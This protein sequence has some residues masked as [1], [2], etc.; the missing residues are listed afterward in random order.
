MSSYPPPTE[1]LPIYNNEAFETEEAGTSSSTGDGAVS[2]LGSIYNF[3]F[4]ATRASPATGLI[5]TNIFQIII[6]YSGAWTGLDLLW[7]KFNCSFLTTF[8]DAS[9]PN[10]DCNLAQTLTGNYEGVWCLHPFNI[11]NFPAP[12]STPVVPLTASGSPINTTGTGYSSNVFITDNTPRE[13][14]WYAPFNTRD[15][16]WGAGVNSAVESFTV[17][18][19]A[20]RNATLTWSFQEQNTLATT[21]TRNQQISGTIEPLFINNTNP[22]VVE[23]KTYVANGGINF[24]SNTL[25]YST[26]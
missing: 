3:P 4:K 6:Y 17:S 21:D 14:Y 1:N 26:I 5:S 9:L 12:S 18:L 25:F 7:F 24:N 22:N 13:A 2:G 19:D 15:G 23:I 8:N 11:C 10:N 20:S 16:S